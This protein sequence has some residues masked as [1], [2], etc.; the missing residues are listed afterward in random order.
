MEKDAPLKSSSRRRLL[1]GIATTGVGGLALGTG[2]AAAADWTCDYDCNPTTV[3]EDNYDV[4]N[5]I[6]YERNGNATIQWYSSDYADGRWLHDFVVS[7]AAGCDYNGGALFPTAE[8][9]GHRYKIQ[10]N[11]GEILA[12]T[13]QEY[14]GVHPGGSA[15]EIPTWASVIMQTTVGSVTAG[16]SWL[17]AA[18]SIMRDKLKPAEGFDLSVPHGFSYTTVKGFGVWNLC[19]FHRVRYESDLY[20][21]T[22][23]ARSSIASNTTGIGYTTWENVDFTLNPADGQPLSVSKA[24]DPT[25]LSAT[26]QRD[27]GIQKVPSDVN[28]TVMHKGE[29]LEV[30][31]RAT[32]PPIRSVSVDKSTTKEK[33]AE[34]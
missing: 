2:T 16:A 14:H 15:G 9:F 3:A 13:G 19:H 12:Y 30:E 33:R 32:R 6:N 23:E 21:P 4:Y 8:L 28:R 10:G 29:E 5:S 31:Y 17:L 34:K 25:S 27:L 22:V 24:S 26:E 11:D 7:G 1:S 20:E 18:N